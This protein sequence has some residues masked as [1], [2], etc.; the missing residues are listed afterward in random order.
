ME[1]RIKQFRK[2]LKIKIPKLYSESEVRYI[3]KHSMG[4]GMSGT[5]WFSWVNFYAYFGAFMFW[6]MVIT[7]ILGI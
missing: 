2:F 1:K 5:P 6:G 3:L 7:N 4:F